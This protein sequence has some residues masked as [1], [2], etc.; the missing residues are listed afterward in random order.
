MSATKWKPT[1]TDAEVRAAGLSPNRLICKR[2]HGPLSGEP[3]TYVG[4]M[5][6]DGAVIGIFV[7]DDVSIEAYHLYG[8]V[9][10]EEAGA[11]YEAHERLELLM[12]PGG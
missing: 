3:G 12:F 2:E 7:T 9:W 10:T 1:W 6:S 8:A 4:Y 5:L 11:T